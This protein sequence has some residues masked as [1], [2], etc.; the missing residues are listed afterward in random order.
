MSLSYK[1]IIVK[2]GS[3]VLTQPD[4]MPD[5][6]RMANLVDQITV[7]KNQG[8]EIIVISSGAVAFGRSLVQVKEK[9][10]AVSARQLLAS[11]GQVQLINTYA[12]LFQ[13]QDLVC[14]Q[15]LVSKEDFR[16]RNHYLNMQNCFRV[17]LQN[18]II[19]VVNEN[20]VI[21]ITELMFTD[22]DELA[23]LIASMLDADALL[24]LSNVDGIYNGNPEDPDSE[25]VQEISHTATGFSAFVSTQRSQFGRGGMITK[26]HMAQKVALLG[27]P[28]HIANGKKENVLLKVIDQ[29]MVHTTF[30][31]NKVA[32]S[33]KKWIAH[34]GTY[35][36]GEV[37]VNDGA[38]SALCS[39][40]KAVSLLPVGIMHVSGDFKKGDLVKLVDEQR[41]AIGIGLAE[42]GADKAQDRMG[43]KNQK[44]LV[45]YDYLFINSEGA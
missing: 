45:H 30:L 15:V 29:E 38:K 8:K 39:S 3:N 32:S 43:Q 1:R 33:K 41:K 4:G 13:K 2:I 34:S 21:S 7:L 44:P 9:T 40:D 22:N 35:A 10:D 18:N 20:D 11:V 42:Y 17:L 26:C 19:P 5:L 36:K 16:D 6:N 27:I 31:P 37:Q 23:G 14:A 25:V 12:H 24:I 28:V